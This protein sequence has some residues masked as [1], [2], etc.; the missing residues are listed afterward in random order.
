MRDF[1]IFAEFLQINERSDEVLLIW[2]AGDEIDF[3]GL[4]V[5]V[6]FGEF[7]FGEGLGEN[8]GRV[9][10]LDGVLVFLYFGQ[11]HL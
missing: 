2:D 4:P 6:D 1:I 3:S 9:I 5:E 11:S 7:V 8:G 10:I